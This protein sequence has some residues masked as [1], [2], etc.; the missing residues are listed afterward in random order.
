MKDRGSLEKGSIADITVIDLRKERRIDASRSHSKAKF[1]PFD[2]WK[3]KGM[4]IKTF[5]NGQLTLEN[6]AITSKPGV[7]RIIR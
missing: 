6:G 2:G 1:S 3:T 5:I 4:P 7:G